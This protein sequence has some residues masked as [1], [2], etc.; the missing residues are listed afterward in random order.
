LT[1]DVTIRHLTA[2]ETGDRI[3]DLSAVLIACVHAGA[4]V[5]FMNP[6]TQ[7]RADAFWRAVQN[8]VATGMT[9]LLIAECRGALIGTV[10]LV[11]AQPENQ[12]HRADLAKMLVLP[13]ARRQGVGRALVIAAETHALA[14]GKTLIVLDTVTGGDGERLY[15]SLNWTAVGV[16]PGYALFPDGHPCD[17]TIFYKR[18]MPPDTNAQDR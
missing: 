7:E 17:T 9:A 13:S 4:S 2:S 6:L 14:I 18:L 16:V 5:S 12:P 3:A 10:Q 1:K 8:N 11:S 15:Q